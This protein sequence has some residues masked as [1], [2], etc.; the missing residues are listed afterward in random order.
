MQL[1]SQ[2]PKMSRSQFTHVLPA[3]QQ[4]PN[5]QPCDY[6]PVYRYSLRATFIK[7]FVPYVRREMRTC[8]FRGINLPYIFSL[9]HIRLK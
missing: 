9:I 7:Q 5:K 4:N 1:M 8:I 2:R 3:S 6:K